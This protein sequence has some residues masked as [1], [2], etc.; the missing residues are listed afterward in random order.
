NLITFY[1]EKRFEKLVTGNAKKAEFFLSRFAQADFEPNCHK[2]DKIIIVPIY[3]NAGGTV[4]LPCK[5]CEWAFV[6]W[7]H[8]PLHRAT[9]FLKNPKD[10]ITGQ[11]HMNE[12]YVQSLSR[13]MLPA[14][15]GFHRRARLLKKM[16]RTDLKYPTDDEKHRPPPQKIASI[17]HYIQADG[18]LYIHG[19]MLESSG[20]YFCHDEKSLSAHTRVFFLLMA[21]APLVYHS[22]VTGKEDIASIWNV[23]DWLTSGEKYEATC[24]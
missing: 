20:V 1:D 6:T 16:Y 15:G 5:M 18:R 4:E 23:D 11:Y 2:S 21:M 10:F 24:A 14:G 8:I 9:E 17:H 22:K 12:K 7:K 13:S 19:T 3:F